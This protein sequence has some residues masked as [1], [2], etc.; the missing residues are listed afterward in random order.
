MFTVYIL[1]NS[2]SRRHYVGSTNNLV[3][4]I[5][6][7]NRGHTKSTRQKGNWEVIYTEE[8]N[9]E[10][11]ARKRE[12]II[13]SYKGGNAFRKLIVAVVQR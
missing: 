9:S 10:L 4:R 8:Y 12:I 11:E 5:S 13:K 7:H 3:R 6:E 1:K 2:I